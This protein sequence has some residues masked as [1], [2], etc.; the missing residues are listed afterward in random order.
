MF[1]NTIDKKKEIIDN[2]G[3]KIIDLTTS[4]F[5]KKAAGFSGFNTVKLSETYEMRPDKVSFAE[6]G[7]IDSTEFILKYSGISNPFSLA[8]DDV[9]LVPNEEAAKAQMADMEEDTKEI[10]NEQIKNY[11]K[12]TNK[13]FKTDS[14]AYDDLANKKIESGVLDPT[15]G[16]DYV[17]PYISNNGTA[18]ITI[19]NGR[20]Y[21][22]EDNY[23]NQQP[24]VNNDMSSKITNLL[25][26]SL[27]SIQ[28]QCAINGMSTADFV[29]AS[30]KNA[31]E[32]AV[33]DQEISKINEN[34][35][36]DFNF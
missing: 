25:Q 22:G 20:M 10:K 9:L 5:A 29:R 1:Q 6:Y 19:K 32:K 27:S 2:K 18:A 33:I 11:Y 28:D 31:E 8:A 24:S 35:N 17:V 7:N 3:N 16:D 12:F 34:F 15:E 13:D 4:I 26:N 14:T 36:K 23:S 30:I 21:F